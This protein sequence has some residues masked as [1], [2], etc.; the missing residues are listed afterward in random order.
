M[1]VLGNRHPSER[2]FWAE[3]EEEA[4]ALMN[5][6]WE[7]ATRDEYYEIVSVEPYQKQ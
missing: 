2:T 4:V 6:W 5:A 3:D 1:A 7:Y